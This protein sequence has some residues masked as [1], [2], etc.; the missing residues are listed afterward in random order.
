MFKNFKPGQPIRAITVYIVEPPLLLN[1]IPT[2]RVRLAEHEDFNFD[3]DE[4]D[5]DDLDDIL[6]E[7]DEVN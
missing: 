5:L 3:F 6:A 7:D 2:A 1:K 4:D